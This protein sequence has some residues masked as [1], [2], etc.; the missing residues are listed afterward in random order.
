M[1]LNLHQ[2]ALTSDTNPDTDID[3]MLI[4]TMNSNEYYMMS[5]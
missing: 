4:L 5:V 3:V 2:L 1:M